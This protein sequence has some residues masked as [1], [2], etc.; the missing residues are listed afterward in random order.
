MGNPVNVAQ[1]FDIIAAIDVSASMQSPSVRNKSISRFKEVEELALGIAMQAAE[2]DDD[3]IDIITFGKGAT[4]QTGVTADKVAAVFAGGANQYQT[5]TDAM[6]RLAA[7]RQKKTGK[8]T[9]C[10]VFTDGEPTD[11]AAVAKAII[12]AS[13]A[14]S[15]DEEL[16]FGFVQVGDDPNATNFLRSLDD[17]LQGKGAKFDIVDAITSTEAA[18]MN[19]AEMLTKFVAD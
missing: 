7:E 8:N 2:F 3:G 17:D 1:G 6:V 13:N 12:D 14:L 10:I 9:I 19:V 11:K 4:I 5:D 18:G 16:T 15:R